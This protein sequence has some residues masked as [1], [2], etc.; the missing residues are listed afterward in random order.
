MLRPVLAIAENKQQHTTARDGDEGEGRQRIKE[1]EEELKLLLL[2]KDP[3]DEKDV[4]L[5]IRAGRATLALG[6]GMFLRSAGWRPCSDARPPPRTPMS[7]DIRKL[8][9]FDTRRMMTRFV[10]CV[11]CGVK[12]GVR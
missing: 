7:L 12:L 11:D 2:P 9:R 4:M 8:T 6:S 5:E 10:L 1:L 3:N